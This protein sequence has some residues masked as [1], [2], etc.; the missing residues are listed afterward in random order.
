M[1]V[2]CVVR[3]CGARVL[4]G[5]RV[6]WRARVLYGARVSCACAVWCACVVACVRV[7]WC[8]CGVRACARAHVDSGPMSGTDA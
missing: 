1:C 8:A 5:V 4:L 6:S 2:C 7:V 3:L